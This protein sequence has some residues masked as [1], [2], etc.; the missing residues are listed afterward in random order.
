ML[1][2]KV[3]HACLLFL[4]CS[5]IFMACQKDDPIA[6]GQMQ[7]EIT[8]GPVDDVDVKA[9]FVTVADVKVDG[10]SWAGFAG[11]TTVDLMAYQNGVTKV[12]GNGTLDGKA[13]SDIVLVLDYDQD[14]AGNSPGC[15]VLNDLNEKIK[16][17]GNATQEIKIRGDYQPDENEQLDLV[18]DFDLR[19]AL[20]YDDSNSG[21]KLVSN[22][23][24]ENALRLVAKSETGVIKGTCTDALS[25]SEKIVVYAYKKGTFNL[26]TEKTPQGDAQIQFKNAVTSAAVANNGAYQLSFL[27]NGDYELHFVSYIDD[28]ED[29]QLEAAGVLEVSVVGDFNILGLDLGAA[30]TLD[31]AVLVTGVVPI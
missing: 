25:G 28:D 6:S 3:F 17:T 13:Y 29:G 2:K 20:T 22:T 23:E 1:N 10:R 14:S 31:L 19:K 26:E 27:E 12:L 9:V 24:L 16:L 30:V 11:K 21:F 5:L 7:V 15:Y 4:S 8:D 18:V